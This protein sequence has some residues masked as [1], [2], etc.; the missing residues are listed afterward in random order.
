[1]RRAAILT[2]ILTL[3][4][5]STRADALDEVF[6]AYAKPDRPGCAVGVARRGEAAVLRGYGQ[7][8]LEHGAAITAD[9][10][11][12]AG[13]VSKQFTAAATLLLVQDG[14]LALTDDI[15][16]Y[17]PEMP[18]YAAPITIDHL[19]SHT[20]GLRDWGEVAA[21]SGW[22]RSS[23]AYTNEEALEITARQTGLNY[24]VGTEWSYTN[25]GYNLLAVIVQRVSGQ[26]LAAFTRDRLFTP[27]GM[28][29]T[30]WRDDFR[31]VVPG[32]AIAYDPAASGW[33]QD[34]PFENVYGNG[35][36]LTT[37]GDL[38]TWN[39]A[40]TSGKLGPEVT[41]RLQQQ[42]V[43]TGG[44]KVEYARGL[45]V[46]SYHG[47]REVSHDGATAGYRAWLGR[48]P[49]QGLS[50]ALLCNAANVN[51]DAEAHKVADLYLPAA[52]SEAASVAAAAG[53][54]DAKELASRPG[55]YVQDGP[56]ATVRV[57]ADAGQLRLQGGPVLTPTGQGRYRAGQSEVAFRANGDL[58]RR[59][60]DGRVAVFA[61]VEPA[62]PMAGDLAQLAG[63]YVSDEA[64]AIIK[65]SVKG[66]FLMMTPVGRPSASQLLS[67]MFKD[68][69][70][71]PGSLLRVVRDKAG[72]VTGLRYSGSRVWDL[73][74][75]RVA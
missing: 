62:P 5:S 15:R 31:R 44:R 45:F 49:D 67:R 66:D 63:T 59:T 29:R 27:L 2:A 73:R 74:F 43:L 32:R 72:K 60:P 53:T 61:H 71:R 14:K 9:T 46:S 34:M 39:E 64:A 17:L 36:L 22:P 40:L 28:S 20:S 33:L 12:E 25:T 52:A 70:G 38:L 18:A 8:D 57:S 50:I 19:L 37:V 26:S 16:K 21:L 51:S 68:G 42:A 47:L 3:A 10:I 24:P 6:S 7:A 69:Y 41:A 75:R 30:A 54:M 11:F 55:M 35:G 58:E 13:S 65:L 1:M 4:A 23:K 48:Y 56:F